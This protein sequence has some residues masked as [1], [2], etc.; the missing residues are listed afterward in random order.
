M[1]QKIR[2]WTV[3]AAAALALA[4]PAC[5]AV[6]DTGAG[7]PGRATARPATVASPR[8]AHT[9]TYDGYSLM[10]DGKRTYVWSGE[11]HY[12]RLPSPGLWRDALQ[13]MKAAGFNAASIYFDW[14]Y[15]SPKPGVYDFTGVRNVDQLL[16]IANEVGIY[17]I[18]RPG[19]YINAEVN[20]GAGALDIDGPDSYPQGFNCSSPTSWHGLPNIS[21]DHPAGRPLY[22]PE[23]QGGSFDPWGGPG[24]DKCRQLTGP[25][26]ESVFYKQNI[27]V[28]A[29]A[30]S[31]YMTYGGTSWGWQ[32]DPSQV[33]T[34]YDY[35]AP[36][37]ESRQLTTKY[38]E[39]KLIGYLT[40][41]VAPLTKTD[42]LA[43][44]KPSSPAIVDTARIN[45]DT[46][47]QFHTL[48]HA[49]ATSTST[50]ST[51]IAL[52]LGARSTYT[53]DDADSAL[54][55]TGAWSHV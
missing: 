20:G 25:D 44:A 22:T 1:R 13:K 26:F 24:Y 10:I 15:H 34:S 32:S 21:Y 27:A 55:Y 43:V 51:H 4:L 7:V 42:A 29:T 3:L 2:G 46:H 16:D 39:D 17:V 50:D 37:T 19:P 45:P 52:D 41:S 36:I 6:A 9:V 14:A 31:F 12:S 53:Y 38:D 11:F 30:Q 23:F 49:N 47:T 48:R 18:A 5:N 54:Q 8:T 28:G 40:Q 35:G 33:Y